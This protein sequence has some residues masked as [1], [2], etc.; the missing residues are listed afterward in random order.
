LSED[1]NI[2]MIFGRGGIALANLAEPTGPRGRPLHRFM[3]EALAI[4]RRPTD[5]APVARL[6]Q[7]LLL[8]E[9]NPGPAD[10]RM[11]PTT[12]QALAR[13]KTSRSIVGDAEAVCRL[14]LD[15][16]GLRISAAALSPRG[17]LFAVAGND[18]V[19]RIVTLPTE[20][21]NLSGADQLPIRGHSDVIT[22]LVFS[23][24]GRYLASIDINGRFW[25]TDVPRAKQIARWLPHDLPL[26]PAAAEMT[27]TPSRPEHTIPPSSAGTDPI[28]TLGTAN[29]LQAAQTDIARATAVGFTNVEIYQLRD[30]FISAARFDNVQSQRAALLRLRTLPRWSRIAYPGFLSELCPVRNA[31][32]Q[33][34]TSCT[35]DLPVAVQ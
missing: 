28:V 35:G 19:I 33:G 24:D 17:D 30:R 4:E 25:I 6:Q 11:G 7:A 5:G 27:P 14:G 3:P 34:V 21:R 12:L 20:L 15:C 1:G 2:L 29:S 16:P 18:H 9:F 8:N 13:Y 32:S 26:G 23:S 22:Q 10:G 31:V